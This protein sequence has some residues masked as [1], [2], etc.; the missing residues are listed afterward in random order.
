MEPPSPI[1]ILYRGEIN[2]SADCPAPNE[3]ELSSS[4]SP[5]AQKHKDGEGVDIGVGVEENATDDRQDLDDAADD[6]SFGDFCDVVVAPQES[7]K[8]THSVENQ[9][10]DDDDE[11]NDIDA[12]TSHDHEDYGD[13]LVGAFHPASS[14][15]TTS[16]P[17]SSTATRAEPGVE[18]DNAHDSAQEGTRWNSNPSQPTIVAL[19][20]LRVDTAVKSPD[21]IFR[22]SATT[23]PKEPPRPAQNQEQSN[24][25]DSLFLTAEDH[26]VSEVADD[27]S[28][29]GDDSVCS[30]HSEIGDVPVSLR[31]PTTDLSTAEG[32]FARRQK[33]KYRAE[34]RAKKLYNN[35]QQLSTASLFSVTSNPGD[36]DDEDGEPLVSLAD[37][38]LPHYYFTQ[39]NFDDT[40]RVLQDA[41]WHHI[42]NIW[43]PDF[44]DDGSE[45]RTIST[46]SFEDVQDRRAL[47]DEYITQELCRLDAA[48]NQVSKHLLRRIQ[49]HGAILEEANQSIHEFSTN[50]DIA[51]MYLKRSQNAVRQAAMGTYS[52]SRQAFDD[53]CGWFGADNLLQAWRQ[54]EMYRGLDATLA[55]IQETLSSEKHLHKRVSEFTFDSAQPH[56]YSTIIQEAQSLQSNVINNETLSRI[57]ALDDL[58]Q[59]LARKELFRDFYNRLHALAES[60]AVRCCRRH[61]VGLWGEYKNLVEAVVQMDQ[62]LLKPSAGTSSKNE[63]EASSPT[64]PVEETANQED[65]SS[66]SDLSVSWPTKILE[67]VYYEADR[68]FA[69]ALLDPLVA[70]DKDISAT[71]MVDSEFEQELTQLGYELQQ[72]WGDVAKLRTITHNLVIIRFD[73]ENSSRYLL[74]VYHRLCVKLADVLYAH[75]LFG[76]WHERLAEDQQVRMRQDDETKEEKV[77]E[78]DGRSLERSGNGE[79][80]APLSFSDSVRVEWAKSKQGV[81]DRCE[82][83]LTKCLEEYL[84]FASHQKLFQR[85]AGGRNVDGQGTGSAN[86]E[87]TEEPLWGSDLME[88]HSVLTLTEEF[89]SLK[90]LF[91]KDQSGFSSPGFGAGLQNKLCDVFRK[92]LRSVHVEAM[93]S[94]GSSLSQENWGMIP[95]KQL[96]DYE[97]SSNL[98]PSDGGSISLRK[99]RT[100]S[101]CG[102]LVGSTLLLIFISAHLPF[103]HALVPAQLFIGAM[104]VTSDGIE[105]S[106]KSCHLS[107]KTCTD[108]KRR[109]LFHTPSKASASSNNIFLLKENHTSPADGPQ[110]LPT[111]EHESSNSV[112]SNVFDL[113]SSVIAGGDDANSFTRLASKSVAE[114]FFLWIAR[115]LLIMERLPLIV[116]D[117]SVVFAN[118]SDLYFT[119]VL[120]ICA[121]SAS[122]EQI[123]FGVDPPTAFVPNVQAMGP[124]RSENT[125]SSPPLFGFRMRSSSSLG[126]SRHQK[127][128]VEL[129]ATLEADICAP[130][131]TEKSDLQ[132]TLDFILRA[133][134][135]LK[136][137]VLLDKVD[138]WITD[139]VVV[140]PSGI[141]TQEE[142]DSMTIRAI[143]NLEERLGAAWSCL[144]VA[145]ILEATCI[146]ARKKL[147]ASVLGSKFV[148]N[149]S[150]LEHYTQAVVQMLPKMIRVSTRIASARSVMA[151]RVVAEV[152]FPAWNVS[153]KCFSSFLT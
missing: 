123:L 149:L 139:P 117:I 73:W 13:F 108:T 31:L 49:P 11:G 128:K 85:N 83:V 116:D 36:E 64:A 48:Q 92:H 58:R 67:A 153:S 136:D 84:H 135:T 45:L 100:K 39:G 66:P 4:Q 142:Y 97:K 114:V 119:T 51:Q 24:P 20:P 91:F 110:N 98:T 18:N 106:S 15:P 60:V 8:S 55:Q 47:W 68:A 37:L 105:R 35:S 75:Y 150:T 80:H 82:G 89:V 140:S 41:P 129:P 101:V 54:Q 74:P 12:D 152:S 88:L 144:G 59:R 25:P 56:E 125:P 87:N 10:D 2:E 30:G 16:L 62:L 132:F 21:S 14:S 70:M 44:A 40:V 34:M 43:Q 118:L 112:Q 146:V 61:H 143:S 38:D 28:I 72:G 137:I 79:T 42:T 133:Q 19:P 26:D 22:H 102:R 27:E 99:V 94:L 65:A 115:L 23:N 148:A 138:N 104:S 63:S 151:R 6:E 131:R 127:S 52:H 145:A 3:G 121:G 33:Q 71:S 76:E 46:Y 81:W 86:D 107:A 50:L 93:K 111:D 32:R 103:F 77:E 141:T 1:R 134:N 29:E 126:G 122:S 7:A 124:A 78:A 57:N 9:V 90:P 96:S 113:I 147:A 120:R 109:S 69:T 95:L 5:D 130:L 53:D 17:V